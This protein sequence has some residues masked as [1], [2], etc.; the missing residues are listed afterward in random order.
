MNASNQISAAVFS[1]FVKCPTKAHL[2]AIG[3]P[4]PGA[5]FV[6]IEARISSMYKPVAKRQLHSRAKVAELLEFGQLLVLFLWLHIPSRA[7]EEDSR[8]T[9][10]DL[11][12]SLSGEV[13]DAESRT[14]KPSQGDHQ[15]RTPLAGSFEDR[16]HVQ[17]NSGDPFQGAIQGIG[18][19]D[20]TF[21][22]MYIKRFSDYYCGH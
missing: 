5:F 15:H 2:L 11:L 19:V 18:D 16:K 14:G 17:G 21:I 9:A 3:E 20:I 1:A 6:D 4:A 22:I 8:A 13:L 7:R 10:A 12:V